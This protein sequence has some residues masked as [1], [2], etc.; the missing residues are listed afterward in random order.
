[1]SPDS[2]P[3]T[4][5]PIP[6]IDPV[7]WEERYR[8][9]LLPVFGQPV[10]ELVQGKGAEVVDVDGRQ[11]LDLLAGIAVNSLGHAHPRLVAA[12]SEQIAALGHVSNFFA[13]EPQIRL[14]ERLLAAAA[15]P[16]GSRVYFS[17]SGAEA[18]E[19]AL[20]IA[21]RVPGRS[22]IVAIEGA[23]HG[24]TLGALSV[25]HNP[26]YREPFA[27]LLPGTEFVPFGDVD[28]L[29]AA[30]DD[31]CAAVIIEPIQGEVGVREHPAGY[32]EA[33]RDITRA[34]GALLILDEVQTGIGRTG[35]MFAYQHADLGS[36]A[37]DVI[38]LAK[39]LG[40]GVPIGATLTFGPAVSGLLTAGQH[41]STFAGNPLATAAGNA[42]LDAFEHDG[43]LD[44]VREVSAILLGGLNELDHPLVAGAHGRGLLLGVELNRPLAAHIVTAARAAGFIVNAVKPDTVRLVPPLILRP[45]QAWA[46]LAAV[47][48]ILDAAAALADADAGAANP[49]PTATKETP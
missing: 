48:S 5:D 35:E 33:A 44:G 42:V 38:T 1:M 8:N 15:A 43:L 11:Y 24:R 16:E 36:I 26:K 14:A 29:R 2:A 31:A 34:A 28:A 10:L 22:T 17:N 46:F 19:A 3:A 27:P 49:A 25:T 40:G 41:G 32:L 37:P 39:G 7:G 21:R 12:V 9:S 47:P 23:F 30:V 18:N 4:G 13:T 45:E 20:K 6:A